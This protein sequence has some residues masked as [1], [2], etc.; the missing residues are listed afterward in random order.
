VYLFLIL[1]LLIALKSR[2]AS[3]TAIEWGLALGLSSAAAHISAATR[4][5][6]REKSFCRAALSCRVEVSFIMRMSTPSSTP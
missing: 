3:L 1:T 6:T 4:L 2:S 5:L